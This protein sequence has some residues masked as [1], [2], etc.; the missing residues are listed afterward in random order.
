VGVKG[1]ETGPAFVVLPA[2]LALLGTE[3]VWARRLVRRIRRQ[4]GDARDSF[5]KMMK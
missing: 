1:V 2:G 5:R 4:V 3:F